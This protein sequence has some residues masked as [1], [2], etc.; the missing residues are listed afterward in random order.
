MKLYLPGLLICSLALP[1]KG[2]AQDNEFNYEQFPRD[3]FAA[4]TNVHKPK[5]RK[6]DLEQDLAFLTDDIDYQHLPYSNGDSRAP[7]GKA[8]MRKGMTYY[9][10]IHQDSGQKSVIDNT[11]F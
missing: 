10:G 7:D 2:N 9:L 5:A 6:N 1:L 11:V 8:M 4:W 3:Y